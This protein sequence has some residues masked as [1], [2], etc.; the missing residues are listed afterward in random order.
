[1]HSMSYNHVKLGNYPL[2]YSLFY[3]KQTLNILIMQANSVPLHQICTIYKK[4]NNK[5]GLL[6]HNLN[7]NRENHNV[8]MLTF[9][10]E[11]DM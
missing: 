7:L 10:Y 2:K 9:L 4:P 8:L 3:L 6:T 11:I 1:M 5:N